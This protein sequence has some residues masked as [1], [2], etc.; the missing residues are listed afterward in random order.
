MSNNVIFKGV[1]DG[2]IIS[3]GE[4][5]DFDVLKEEFISK[6]QKSSKFFGDAKLNIKFQGR[7]LSNLEYSQLIDIIKEET[8]IDISYVYCNTDQTIGVIKPVSNDV[9]QA[10][11]IK[12]TVRSGQYIESDD[13]IIVL[14]DVN[15]GAK[16]ISK[17]NILILGSLKGNVT[18]GYEDNDSAFIAASSMKPVQL[19]IGTQIGRCN[20]NDNNT[21]DKQFPQIAFVE[22]DAIYI[23]PIDNKTMRSIFN[24]KAL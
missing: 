21:N 9:T 19:R 14:G 13:S 22:E 6:A 20:D 7:E 5:I 23:E 16:I 12:G 4:D 11:I 18:A 3:L 15:P 24:E 8:Q 1:R 2:I 17:G 10:K